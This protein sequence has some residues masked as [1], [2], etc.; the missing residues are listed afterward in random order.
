MML[1]II[2][3]VLRIPGRLT[4]VIAGVGCALVLAVTPLCNSTTTSLAATANPV[5]RV[6]APYFGSAVTDR[7]AEGAIFWFGKVT[8][9]TN[10]A[11]VRIGY[12]DTQLWVYV[13]VFDRWLWY[14]TSPSP[15]DLNRWDAVTL[16]LDTAGNTGTASRTSAYRFLAQ[17][18]GDPDSRYRLA[19]RGDGQSWQTTSISFDTLPGWR[20]NAL[21]DA[22]DDRGWAMTFRIPFDSLGVGTPHGQ[23]WGI[24]LQV[25]DRDDASGTPIADQI[26]PEGMSAQQS[27][28][29]AQLHF[30][31][32][33]HSPGPLAIR[34]RAS[35][36]HRDG[37]GSEVPDGAVGGYTNC[38]D[39]MDFWTEWGERV[40]YTFPNSTD[41]YGDFN[42]QNQSDIADWPCFS[43]Y[44]VTFPLP[45]RPAGMQVVTASLTMHLFGGAGDVKDRT[46][47]LIQVLTVAEDWDERTMNWN[48]APLALENVSQRWVQP[49]RGAVD[50]PGIPYTWDIGYAVA[51]AY[52]TGQSY[53]RLAVYSADS[54][55][56]SGKYFVSADTGDWNA[57]GRPRL[58]VTF[59]EPFEVTDRVFLPVVR[60]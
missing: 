8:G 38:G 1:S 59:G 4:L 21:N 53:L 15:D 50:W 24:A 33:V 37:N 6:N 14:D 57:A 42:I 9:Q 46:D 52:A 2:G 60:R 31:L 22:E 19:Q 23:T 11:D 36:Y 54:A 40:Y 30:G 27:A 28:T 7:F 25:H 44:Y 49:V 43:R 34:S 55:Y 16:Y 35:V 18:S 26:W 48:N 32:P 3:R 29:W 45:A 39:G 51:K 20:G 41:E 56:H 12:F 10:Y 47:S 5:R 17:L 58:E 13:A